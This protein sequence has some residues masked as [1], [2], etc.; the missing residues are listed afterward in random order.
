MSGAAVLSGF[1]AKEEVWALSGVVPE[2]RNHGQ[3]VSGYEGCS[4]THDLFMDDVMLWQVTE[5]DELESGRWYWDGDVVYIADDP[6]NRRIELSTI[7]Y[8]FVGSADDVVIRGLTVEKYATPAQDGAI[9]SQEP[10]E[11]AFG[12][13]WLIEDV[14]AWG[15]H[16]AAVRAGNRMV[17]RDSRI[18]HNGQLGI[19]CAGTTDVL[20]EDNE[21]AHNNLAGFRWEWEAGGVKVTRSEAL[22]FTGNSVHHN[23]GPGLWADIDTTDVLYEGNRVVDNSGPGIFYEI[24]RRGVIRDNVVERNGFADT[25]WLWGAGI[26]VAGSADVEV[27]ANVVSENG[28]GI[29]GIQQERGDGEFGPHLLAGLHVY[30][31][32]VRLGSGRMGI[33]EDTGD[34]AVFTERGNRFESNTYV[35]PTGGNYLWKNSRLDKSGWIANGQDTD[36][37]WR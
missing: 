6:T 26:L 37:T 3:C 34:S 29:A 9:Q 21:I 24:S 33:V 18:H 25:T 28:N 15:H 14:D 30:D 35:G 16:G 22:V 4:L 13:G 5:R 27:Y 17:I 1:V 32:T 7:T 31:N 23:E 19:T 12:E 20:I 36:G 8:A 2:A 10:G 11:G